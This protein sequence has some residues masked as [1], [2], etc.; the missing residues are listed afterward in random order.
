[1]SGNSQDNNTA[2]LARNKAIQS[3]DLL[4]GHGLLPS[5][6]NYS[7][8]YEYLHGTQADL[9]G[10]L[11]NHLQA[12]KP[13]DDILL[14]DLYERY[15][16]AERHKQFQG[17]RNDLQSLLHA[18][19]Q[20]MS[21]TNRNSLEYQQELE[22]NIHKLGMELD[23][24]TLQSIAADMVVSATAANSQN[25]KL[26]EHLTTAQQETEQLRAEL[27]AQ[28]REAMIDPLTGLFNRRAMDHHME[29][30]WEEDQDLSVLVMDIDHFKHIND[31]YG[32]AIGDIVIRNVADVV[33]KCIRGEDIAVRFGGEE[34]LVLLPNTQLEGA[35]TVAEA[36]RRRIEALRLVRKN[37]NFALA[38][39]TISL[40]VAKRRGNDDRDS[41]VERA[42]KALYQAKSSG[43]NQVMHENHL[44]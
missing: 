10:F 9:N 31:S 16:A 41:L 19:M 44:H 6:L 28:R 5:P 11:D 36:I 20:T 18:L 34:F 23:Q 30:L 12:G 29:Y 33:R 15:I 40:G 17:M 25:R 3:I 14:Q 26:Q 37:D 35:I 24:A 22:A 1:M 39:F 4:I 42:D 8:A 13:L 32:H 7:V 27:E 2:E 43:R 38:P 21:E